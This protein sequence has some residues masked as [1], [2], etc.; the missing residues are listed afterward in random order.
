MRSDDHCNEKVFSVLS[1]DLYL[2]YF[3]QLISY[4]AMLHVHCVLCLQQELQ[5]TYYNFTLILIPDC[6]CFASL[7]HAM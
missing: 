4:Y 2:Y 1:D 7:D 3:F 6:V 5:G